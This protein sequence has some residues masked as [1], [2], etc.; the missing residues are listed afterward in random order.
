MERY[1][2]LVENVQ[3]LDANG[4]MQWAEHASIKNL[5]ASL[6]MWQNFYNVLFQTTNSVCSFYQFLIIKSLVAEPLLSLWMRDCFLRL[7][8]DVRS[9]NQRV[10]VV[11]THVLHLVITQIELFSF[12]SQL[13]NLVLVCM[14][15]CVACYLEKQE[16][17]NRPTSCALF[18]AQYA[19]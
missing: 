13:I 3:N 2:V 11:A 7:M 10:A 17:G 1:L 14:L 19:F 5:I 4:I 18:F 6:K 8:T 15:F 16:C 12:R 9:E